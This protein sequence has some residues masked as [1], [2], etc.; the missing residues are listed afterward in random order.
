[1]RAVRQIGVGSLHLA[2]AVKS[3]EHQESSGPFGSVFWANSARSLWMIKR[4]P[5]EGADDRVVEVA[6]T[7]KKSNTGRLLAPLGLR[8]TFDSSRTTIQNM[9][10]AS[11]TLSTSLPLWQRMRA[12]VAAHAMTVEDIALELDAQP[13]SVARAVQ[14]MEIFRR[15]GDGRIWLSSQLSAASEP[16]DE[17]R[18]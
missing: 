9:D 16:P 13:K 11:S 15:G 10:L 6:L 18:F 1:M 7:H 8:L 2:H 5:G 17:D 12:L 3:E 14:R 4:A